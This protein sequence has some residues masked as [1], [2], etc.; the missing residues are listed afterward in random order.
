MSSCKILV[1][2]RIEYINIE[3]INFAV[4][5]SLFQQQMIL[6]PY[7]HDTEET[8]ILC[9][10]NET[11]RSVAIKNE[12]YTKFDKIFKQFYYAVTSCYKLAKL[13]PL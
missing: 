7:L 4:L 6:V 11:T 2:R 8:I 12:N 1:T 13:V 9:Y 10:I 5:T 3:Y